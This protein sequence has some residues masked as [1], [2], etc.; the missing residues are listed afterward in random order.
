MLSRHACAVVERRTTLRQLQR[1]DEECS[2]IH[3]SL[4]TD[5]DVTQDF[6]VIDDILYRRSSPNS[7]TIV[8]PQKLRQSVLEL[9]HDNSGHMDVK[10]TLHTLQDRYWW[11]QMT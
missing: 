3:K 2:A 6:L 4:L 5:G 8:V 11:P 10:H 9:T 7:N 1:E